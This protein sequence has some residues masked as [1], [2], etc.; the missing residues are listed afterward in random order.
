MKE[1]VVEKKE[2]KEETNDV[3]PDPGFKINQN[4]RKLA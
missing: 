4:H 2:T 1:L 3:D